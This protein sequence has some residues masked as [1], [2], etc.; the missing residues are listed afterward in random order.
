ME[1]DLKHLVFEMRKAQKEFF[2]TRSKTSLRLAKVLESQVDRIVY[3]PDEK[4]EN[5]QTEMF[6]EGQ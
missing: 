6:K 5:K 3:E 2:A 1:V 4:K